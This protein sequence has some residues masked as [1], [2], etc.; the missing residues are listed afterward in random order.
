MEKR[1]ALQSSPPCHDYAAQRCP[2]KAEIRAV[3]QRMSSYAGS[4]FSEAQHD[5]FCTKVKTKVQNAAEVWLPIQQSQ[6][7]FET[8]FEPFDPEDNE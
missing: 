2:I 5:L 6:K 3:V 8:D 1:S 7:K 4:L